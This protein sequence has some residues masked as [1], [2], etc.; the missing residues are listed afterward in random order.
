M[1]ANTLIRLLPA[2]LL[3]LGSTAFTACSD[4]DDTATIPS[5]ELTDADS[6]TAGQLSRLLNVLSET[7]DVTEGWATTQ[8]P[9]TEG[10]P[11]PAHSSVRLV[12]VAS[13]QE[14]L[15]YY[16]SLCGEDLAEGTKQHTW[17]C[18][19]LGSL[20]YTYKGEPACH[21]TIDVAIAQL[22]AL[23]QIRLVPASALG[24]NAAFEPYYHWGDVILNHRDN[25]Y[26]VCARPACA[27][28]G[29]S[30]SYWFS[31]QLDADSHTYTVSEEPGL[32]LPKKLG[33][34]RER[35][36][37]LGEML[38]LI[39]KPELYTSKYFTLHERPDGLGDICPSRTAG[40]R[41]AMQNE[42][43]SIRKFWAQK[44]VGRLL[45]PEWKYLNDEDIFERFQ[46]SY[47]IFYDTYGKEKG[48]YY[49]PILVFNPFLT[50]DQAW[51]SLLRYVGEKLTFAKTEK[52]NARDYMLYYNNIRNMETPT[53]EDS[54]FWHSAYA[55]TPRMKTGYQLSTSAWGTP[56]PAKEL[57]GVH[58]GTL[59]HIY[60][61][62]DMVK[63]AK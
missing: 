43:N 38:T 26:W 13:E 59:E 36:L 5:Q 16:A 47:T 25:S 54:D 40:E 50:S 20:T 44:H 35:A 24:N 28:Y 10:E 48:N 2:A 60:L 8:Y 23:T 46:S 9:V 52:F 1:K 56:D 3:A 45:W 63:K 53:S 19:G 57:P 4:D 14:A 15:S 51:D 22:S 11:D 7:S 17:S 21:A 37:T 34:T 31:F 58:N 61:Y 29:K 27:A 30:K 62:R 39:S 41:Q 55:F 6:P 49:A 33:S 18:P 42:L 32:Y 12:A